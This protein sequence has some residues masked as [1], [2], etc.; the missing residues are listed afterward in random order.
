MSDHGT[1]NRYNKGCRCADCKQAKSDYMRDQY[2]KARSTVTQDGNTQINPAA[3]HGT[4]RGYAEFGCH[5]TPCSN[6]DYMYRKGKK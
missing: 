4:R 1:A 3:P 5:C 6:A 2:A